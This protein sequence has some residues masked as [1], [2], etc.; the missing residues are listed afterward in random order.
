MKFPVTTIADT[1]EVALANAEQKRT[2]AAKKDAANPRITAIKRIIAGLKF[3]AAKN[4][5]NGNTKQ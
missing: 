3:A 4:A 2:I 5:I 1:R